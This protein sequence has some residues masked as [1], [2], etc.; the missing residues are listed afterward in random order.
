MIHKYFS[1]VHLRCRW[2]F[3]FVVCN[4][5]IGA[6]I[7][8][9]FL[10]PIDF[11]GNIAS[12]AY[13]ASYWVAHFTALA[14]GA[15]LLI[16]VPLNFISPWNRLVRGI[17]ILLLTLGQILLLIDT[18]VFL[19]YRFHINRFIL[20]L[21]VNDT[22]G[23]IF[24]FSNMFWIMAIACAFVL[25]TVEIVISE[26]LWRRILQKKRVRCF[27]PGVVF[28]I[29][30]TVSAH[31]SHVWADANSFHPITN[32]NKI[33][34]LSHP[35]TSYKLM[36]K[37]GWADPEAYAKKDSLKVKNSAANL[38]YPLAPVQCRPTERPLNV[39]LVVIDSWRADMLSSQVSPNIY[40][41]AGKSSRYESHFSGSNSTRA[42]I[43]SLFYGLPGHY[44]KAMKDS[45][46]PPVLVR[47]LLRQDY[48]FGVF[49]AARLDNPRFNQTVFQP[50]RELRLNTPGKKTYERDANLT[51]DWKRWFEGE[52]DE[53]K[54]FFGFLFYD[55]PHGFS[56]PPDYKKPFEPSWENVNQ[57]LLNDDF[58]ATPFLNRYKNAVHYTD[59]LVGEV[60]AHLEAQGHLEDTV[61]IVTGDHGEEF[62]DNGKGFWGHNG[63]F[64]PVQVQVPMVVH[65]PGRAVQSY[66]HITSHYD[67]APTLLSNVLKCSNPI[68]DYSVGADLVNQKERQDWLLVAS[69]SSYAILEKDRITEIDPL[70][71]YTIYD[72]S[73]RQMNKAKLNY[74]VVLA[75]MKGLK[76]FTTK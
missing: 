15:W 20:D 56:F 55:S 1:S 49:A 29:L 69:Y 37:Y 13:V 52:R 54:P 43:F 11:N 57:M 58:D 35:T 48:Q 45:Q 47:E 36:K 10:G 66:A 61:V 60:L 59:S 17:G 19:N 38:N 6:I 75:A 68:D 65:W 39:L 71:N 26:W 67:V 28:C 2:A 53:S 41:F 5:I 64:S 22:E 51:G 4:T 63:N 50:L 24:S 32:Y 72:Y 16:F 74:D 14:L 31:A 30:L 12:Y 42:G 7:S 62:N 27:G 3:W 21:I 73:Y 23:Q 18:F 8:L 44:W 70:G 76:R 46:T 34:P 40:D 33:L 25:L 9:R